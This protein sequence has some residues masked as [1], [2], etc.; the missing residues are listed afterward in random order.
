MR[1]RP[2]S[3]IHGCRSTHRRASSSAHRMG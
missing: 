3:R 2:L 1:V